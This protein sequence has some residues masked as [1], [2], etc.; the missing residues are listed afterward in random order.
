MVDPLIA[1]LQRHAADPS[2]TTDVSAQFP[3][4]A[5]PPL[6]DASLHRA[7]AALGFQLPALLRDV[8]RLVGNGGIGPG[9]GLVPLVYA[10]STVRPE[11]YRDSVVE[12]YLML[13]SGTPEDLAG[14]WPERL[15]P[16]CEW[17]CAISSCVDCSTAEGAISTFDPN[18]LGEGD[19]I[20]DGFA[21]THASLRTWFEGWIAGARLWDVMFDP[22]LEH[23][24]SLTNQYTGETYTH[25]G[26]K[27]RRAPHDG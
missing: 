23:P 25:F 12:S 26:P 4:P 20:L 10:E 1:E 2:I 21:L 8:Y 11:I 5:L 6:D 9:Y 7:E 17:G 13:R 3:L 22:D 15:L 27:L 18:G 24:L 19:S 14:A 16:F